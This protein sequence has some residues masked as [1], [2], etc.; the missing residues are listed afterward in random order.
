MATTKPEVKHKRVSLDLSDIATITA[1]LRMFQ[2]RYDGYDG[3]DIAGEWPEQF[4]TKDDTLIPPLS[5][6]DIDELCKRL[7]LSAANRQKASK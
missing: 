3:E 5:T 6:D 2:K 4:T 1:G 7:T